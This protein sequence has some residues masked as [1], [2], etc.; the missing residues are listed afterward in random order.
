MASNEKSEKKVAGERTAA[1]LSERLDRRQLSRQAM[2]GGGSVYKGPLATRALRAVGARAMTVDRSIIVRED[3][4]PSNPEDQALYAHEAYHAEHG[5]GQGGGGGT[6]YR[7]AEEIAARGVER[8]V[9]HRAMSGGY[10]AG[11]QPGAGPGVH[12]PYSASDHGG[13]GVG[14]HEGDPTTPNESRTGP[15]PQR[16]YD[17]LRRN[18]LTHVEVVELLARKVLGNLDEQHEV[19]LDRHGDKKGPF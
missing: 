10:E 15:N 9:F 3:F 16:G 13:R 1:K 19:L 5:D 7:D 11:Y 18:D 12:A 4:D 17:A 6:N 2:P 14:T 8:M